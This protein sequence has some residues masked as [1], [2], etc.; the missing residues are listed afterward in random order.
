[1]PPARGIRMRVEAPS[2]HQVVEGCEL[3]ARGRY[4]EGQVLEMRI[5]V[6]DEDVED[7]PPEELQA[8]GRA[9]SSEVRDREEALDRHRAVL[10][11]SVEVQYLAAVDGVHASYGVS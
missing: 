2:A 9:A 10:E 5:G 7:R 11:R 4:E 6:R 8:R 3:H 1:M